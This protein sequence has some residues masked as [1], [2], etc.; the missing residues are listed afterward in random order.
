MR[1]IDQLR[2]TAAIHGFGYTVRRSANLAGQIL[3]GT[4]DRKWRGEKASADELRRQR[5]NCPDAG[6]I[7][8]VIPVYNT[9]PG[10]LEALLRSLSEQSYSHWE[11]VLYDG[12]S[13]RPETV[14]VLDRAAEKE[15]RFRVIHGKENLGIS[16][17]TNKAIALAEGGYVALCD[18]DDLLS[19]DALW[20]VAGA[21]CRDDPDMIYSD[22]DMITENGKRHIDPHYKPDYCP[23]SLACDNYI[24]HLTVIRKT[25]LEKI[26]GLR[27]G[28]DGSQDH[29]LFLRCAAGT[30]RIVHLPYTLYSWRKVRSSMSRRNLQKCLDAGCRAAE[31][32]AAAL[33]RKATALPVDKKIRL[34]YGIPENV[35]VEA[36]IH[37][38][39]VEA[40]RECCD[41][42]TAATHWPG[43][44]A[45]LVVTD[46]GGRFAALNE[47]AAGSRAD[48]LL[49]LDASVRIV[50]RHFFRELLMYA[51]CDGVAGVTP[52]ITD[53]RHRI[54]HGGFAAGVKGQ[55]QCVSE[56]MRAGAGGWHDMMNKVHNVSAVSACCTL[57]RRDQF[58]PF[59][60]RFRSG[61]G[62]VEQGLRQ[63]ELGRRFVYTPYAEAWTEPSALLLN[64]KER[65]EK[66]AAL[67]KDLRGDALYDPCYS[68]RYRKKKADWRAF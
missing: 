1:I 37:G 21:I 60:E 52:V 41:Q 62:S 19:A 4:Y 33:G 55:A 57:I 2:E 65:N 39:S 42:L 29:D 59:D 51:Q 64:G 45:A 8:V 34:W 36:L 20:R 27:P 18:H 9:D 53:S 15:T 35:T 66:D 43:L 22:E 63:L 50:T 11:A 58:L 31:D 38:D 54:I 12:C 67:L 68:G 6:L 3:F 7:S 47:A 10:M 23:E 24:C 56:G 14:A 5:D 13:T 32:H 48:Y 17:N 40:C 16:G 46:D 30:D 49:L 44:T 28:F 26:G 61:L 25:L